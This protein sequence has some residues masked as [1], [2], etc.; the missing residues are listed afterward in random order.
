VIKWGFALFIKHAKIGTWQ[1]VP[2]GSGNVFYGIVWPIIAPENS[3]S[4]FANFIED[5]LL[6]ID[7]A[8]LHFP[9]NKTNNEL[10]VNSSKSPR[11]HIGFPHVFR[12]STTS[13]ADMRRAIYAHCRRPK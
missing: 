4:D 1:G 10:K 6:R 2:F 9:I 12:R 5:G 11:N 13:H 7:R 3:L 8:E